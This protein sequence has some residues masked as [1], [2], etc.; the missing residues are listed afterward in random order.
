[1]TR[2]QKDFRCS[3]PKGYNLVSISPHWDSESPSKAKIGQLQI[4]A[5]IDEKVLR[6]QVPMKDAVRVAIQKP[7]IQLISELLDDL[8]RNGRT[9]LI[10]CFNV[11]LEIYIQELEN[12]V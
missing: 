2:T 4:V 12:K 10:S 9:V 3:V 11:S 6:F 7:R 5:F 8:K 1:M